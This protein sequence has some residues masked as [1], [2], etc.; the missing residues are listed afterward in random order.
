MLAI[1]LEALVP[2][3]AYGDGQ[4]EMAERAV[5]EF[6][7]DEPAVG[8]EALQVARLHGN[9]LAAQI[10]CRIH[11]MAS[12]RQHVILLQVGFR[13][14]VRPAACRAPDDQRLDG[15]RHRVTVGRI[16]IPGL[17]GQHVTHL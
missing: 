5:G 13:V 17:E 14:V 2:V 3:H 16:T 6:D 12:M 10:A 9:D 7:I 15:V 11:E 4:V 1:E 8:A